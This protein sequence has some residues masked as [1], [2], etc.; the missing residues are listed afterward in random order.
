MLPG[1]V[2]LFAAGLGTRM[3]PL[4]ANRPKPLIPVAGRAL[5]DH[6]LDQAGDG[7]RIV[8]NLHYLPDLIR[9][10]LAGR[11]GILFSDESA[12]LL[13]TG[14]GLRKALPLLQSDPVCTLNSDAVWNGPPALGVLADAWDPAH[15]EALLLL[16]P[17][18]RATGHAGRGDFDL[19]RDG[20][21]TRGT[22]FV[23]TGAQILRTSGLAAMPP[24]PFSLNLL[25]NDMAARGRLSG[26]VYPGDWCDVGQPASIALAERMLER[27][28][29]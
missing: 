4:T 22:A 27:T 17:R 20:R 12:Q 24:G 8:V 5:I 10:H 15:M 2:M 18:D 28:D 14:G 29:V 19:D 16:V 7:A 3:A 9:A 1:S 23:Y 21:L 13:E 25:W 26:Q 11:P 6:A